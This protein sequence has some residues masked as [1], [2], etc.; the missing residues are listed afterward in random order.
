M[1][2]ISNKKYVFVQNI[3]HY[4]KIENKS[5]KVVYILFLKKSLIKM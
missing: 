5:Q 4:E 1:F 2:D 3:K